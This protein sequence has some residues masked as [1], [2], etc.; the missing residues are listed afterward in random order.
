MSF[1]ILNI[2]DPEDNLLF[3]FKNISVTTCTRAYMCA[4]ITWKQFVKALRIKTYQ[5]TIS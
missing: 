1:S 4:E 3:C 5:F 2:V